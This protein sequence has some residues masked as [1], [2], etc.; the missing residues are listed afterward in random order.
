MWDSSSFSRLPS[1]PCGMVEHKKSIFL[2][3]N[4]IAGQDELN[5][6]DQLQQGHVEGFP[7]GVQGVRALSE[8]FSASR[9]GWNIHKSDCTCWEWGEA[10]RGHRGSRTQGVWKG[11]REWHSCIHA[12][13]L[14]LYIRTQHSTVLKDGKIKITSSNGDHSPCGRHDHQQQ[15]HSASQPLTDCCLVSHFPPLCASEA[16]RSSLH[17]Q[18]PPLKNQV[19]GLTPKLYAKLLWL[20]WRSCVPENLIQLVIGLDDVGVSV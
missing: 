1:W 9:I 6:K 13:N 7:G 11:T 19:A 20:L 15:L 5:P 18:Q 14:Y 16:D 10:V 12:N 4:W 8:P 3:N 17:Y 2:G